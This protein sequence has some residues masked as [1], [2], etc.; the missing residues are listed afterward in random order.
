MGPLRRDQLQLS[1]R[2]GKAMLQNKNEQKQNK[3]KPC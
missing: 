1:Q 2:I 3:S